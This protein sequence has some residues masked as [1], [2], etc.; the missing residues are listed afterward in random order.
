MSIL[1]LAASL[2]GLV[3]T[4][5]PA[6]RTTV[7]IEILL[8]SNGRGQTA[9][10]SWSQKVGQ[11]GYRATARRRTL[12]DEPG[13]EESQ[14]GRLRTVVAT[15]ELQTDGSLTLP[16]RRFARGA[17]Q[18]LRDWLDE[19]K[20]YGA[21]GRPGDEPQFG[22]SDEAFEEVADRVAGPAPEVGTISGV[23]REL[24]RRTASPVRVSDAV[25]LSV[26]L[27]DAPPLAFGTAAAFQ[28][29]T[30]DLVWLPVRQ[31]DGSI[32]VRIERATDRVQ[33][34]PIGWTAAEGISDAT[35]APRLFERIEYPFET[36]PLTTF[37][38][39]VQDGSKV[40]IVP[41]K[42]SPSSMKIEIGPQSSGRR[43]YA[44]IKRAAV[45]ARAARAI[46]LDDAGQPFF[47][48]GPT[49]PPGETDTSD[50]TPSTS[51]PPKAVRDAIG[52]IRQ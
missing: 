39:S 17:W 34:W 28:L 49:L 13:V 15:F 11:W 18:P 48:I 45:R 27:P 46:R 1:W 33:A 35:L 38:Q 30:V 10:Q 25:S 4:D 36:Q 22:L 9:A 19:R 52:R 31:P 6:D 47:L 43:P 12:R 51:S 40:P 16:D 37:L 23:A 42:L 20:L 41:F 32:E 44:A 26:L 3:P 14:R 21:R 5:A 7:R 24:A 2:Y 8:P 50:D 29:G